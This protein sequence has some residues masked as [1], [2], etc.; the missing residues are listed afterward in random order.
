MKNSIIFIIIALSFI[1]CHKQFIMSPEFLE[2]PYPLEGDTKTVDQALSNDLTKAWLYYQKGQLEDAMFQIR[3]SLTAAPKTPY[4][5]VMEGYINMALGQMHK[6]EKNFNAALKL[7]ENYPSALNVLA[8]IA[9][10]NENFPLA[11]NLYKKLEQL[12]PDFPYVKIKTAL[13][14]LKTVD[15]YRTIA[16]EAL[17]NRKYISAIESY[18]KAIVVYPTIWELHYDLA[19]IFLE[20]K[21]YK[22]AIVYLQLAVNLNPDNKQAK[23]LLADLLY[24]TGDYAHALDFY[25]DLL[26]YQPNNNN[27]IAKAQECERQIDFFQLPEEFRNAEKSNKV[28]RAI[29]AAYLSFKIPYLSHIPSKRNIILIDISP[30]WAKDFIIKIVNLGIIEP[31]PNHTF[32]PY[33][34]LNRGD[35]AVSMDRLLRLLSTVNPDIDLNSASTEIEIADISKSSSQYPSVAKAVNLGFMDLNEKSQFNA[36]TLVTG[37]ELVT[38]LNKIIPLFP[39]INAFSKTGMN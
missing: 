36:D 32:Q 2:L 11:H 28:S 19:S 30:H 16:Q 37:K 20:L 21:D 22:N 33:A 18:K 17:A 1:S 7:E 23:E 35:L 14:T 24:N 26:L 6:A 15:H 25:K 9:F 39:K 27:W 38:I 29:F 4:L 10:R 3:K 34:F 12:H 31:F 13:A 5:W 8:F